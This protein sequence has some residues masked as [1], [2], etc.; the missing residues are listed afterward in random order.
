MGAAVLV[1]WAVLA[2]LALRG[3]ELAVQ[4]LYKGLMKK[5]AGKSNGS[6]SVLGLLVAT[7]T[8]N[9]QPKPNPEP[10]THCA[11]QPAGR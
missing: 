3:F 5:I 4:P 11:A 6:G 2:A 8:T 1:G 9:L 7:F 10:K